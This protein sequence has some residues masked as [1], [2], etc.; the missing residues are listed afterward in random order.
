MVLK[1]KNDVL[2]L[3]FLLLS[4][5]QVPANESSSGQVGR[6]RLRAIKPEIL[7]SEIIR[8]PV[9]FSCYFPFELSCFLVLNILAM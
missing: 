8:K 4:V 9:S 3:S 5:G 1:N 6:S 7:Y 2:L